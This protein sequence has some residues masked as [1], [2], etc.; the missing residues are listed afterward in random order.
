MFTFQRKSTTKNDT[1][2]ETETYTELYKAWASIQPFRGK[3]ATESNQLVAGNFFVI[4]TRYD[5]RL[6]PKDRAY[7]DG[8]YYDIKSVSQLGYREGLEI[9]AEYKDNLQ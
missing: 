3:E 6:K 4:K 1:G 9:L 7:Y 5:S 2:N 8:D